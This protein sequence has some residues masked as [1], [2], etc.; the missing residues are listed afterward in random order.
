MHPLKLPQVYPVWFVAFL[1]CMNL[2]QLS[3]LEGKHDIFLLKNLYSEKN[4]PAF[5][6]VGSSLVL[7]SVYL[8]YII[9]RNL[10]LYH[11]EFCCFPEHL[12]GLLIEES[13]GMLQ[14]ERKSYLFIP[15][16]SSHFIFGCFHAMYPVQNPSL[17]EKS[18]DIWPLLM[19]VI[20]KDT[21]I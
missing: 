5:S 10:L 20:P 21:I 12:I 3:P 1:L 7:C 11:F 17:N 14:I 6:S 8:A 16:F 4:P 15:F 19:V 18:I 9:K 2:I 13:Q